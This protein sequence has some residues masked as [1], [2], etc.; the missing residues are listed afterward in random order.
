MLPTAARSTALLA[1]ALL[2]T[3]SHVNAAFPSMPGPKAN[4]VVD[5]RWI[6]GWATPPSSSSSSSSSSSLTSP[7]AEGRAGSV[8]E[9]YRTESVMELLQRARR[10]APK[11][12]LELEERATAE[13]LRAL[14]SR[15]LERGADTAARTEAVRAL[16]ALSTK[17]EIACALKVLDGEGSRPNYIASDAAVRRALFAAMAKEPQLGQRALVEFAVCGDDHV[18]A[19]AAD[20]LPDELAPSALDELIR[21]LGSDR[22]L[23]INRAASVAATHP[24]AILIPALVSAQYAPPKPKRGDE[25]WIAIGTAR[26]YIQNQIP[27]VGD[28]STSFQPV[29]G[30]LYEGSLLRIMESMVEIYRTEVHVALE[31]VVVHHTGQPAPPLGYERDRWLAW[32][33]DEFPKLVALRQAELQESGEVKRARSTS[34]ARDS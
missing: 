18:R 4:A 29:I 9:A 16:G 7:A 27:V 3:A 5:G 6:A 23:Y 26:S 21:L 34:G 14:V 8:I 30:T 2:A 19:H 15:G 13:S 25:A 33:R 28:S 11:E 24:A 12:R 32:Y 22:E 17:L 1:I 20:A 31:E 10:A